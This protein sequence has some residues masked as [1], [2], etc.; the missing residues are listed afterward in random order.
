MLQHERRK[1]TSWSSWSLNNDDNAFSDMGC[2]K[3]G[4][5]DSDS[6]G[7]SSPDS[8][9]K[10]L[11][12]NSTEPSTSR[13]AP[14][15]PRVLLP[16]QKE[17]ILNSS[18][19]NID[20]GQ[21]DSSPILRK[22]GQGHSQVPDD[23][24]CNHFLELSDEIILLILRWLPKFVLAKCARVCH[25]WH[26]LVNDESLWRRLDLANKTLSQGALGNIIKK[27]VQVLRLAKAEVR[28][29]RCIA[30]LMLCLS[31][32]QYLDLSMSPATADVLAEIFAVCQ[33]LKKLSLEH[34]HMSETC[35]QHISEN[36][37]LNVLNMSMCQG[38]TTSGIMSVV[39]GCTKLEGLN[40]AWTGLHRHTVV[41][42][43][44]C[45]TP[46]LKR[47]NISGCRENITDEEV[48]QLCRSC[49]NLRELDLSDSTVLTHAALT[50][51]EENLF[52]LEY[53]ALSRCYRIPPRAL[54]DL[55]KLP[56][57]FAL[58]VFG[59]L[60]EEPFQTLKEA[61][62]PIKINQFPFSSIARPTT[63]IRRSSLW[64]LKVRDNV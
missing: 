4:M 2:V 63:G 56:T 14:G 18:A 31:K 23:L 16:S 32:L 21:P 45:L 46:N 57:L 13:R 54:P 52:D 8:D 22:R 49:S 19:D 3:L 1:L 58:D 37:N 59:L 60:Q 17:N 64:G 35:C 51:I 61:L 27:G 33:D 26:R 24:K 25:R 38:L 50:H 36:K 47:L 62:K 48:L 10:H 39:S 44:L 28:K 12:P 9:K 20:P 6:G 5:L 43:A 7:E 30:C 11:T 29:C 42:L 15:A 40:L 53:L 55:K 41:Y 34:C